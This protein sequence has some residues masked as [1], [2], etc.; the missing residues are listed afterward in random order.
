MWYTIR[1]TDM[2]S[3]NRLIAYFH[4]LFVSICYK[5]ITSDKQISKH[6][7]IDVILYTNCEAFKNSNLMFVHSGN[8][9][10]QIEYVD[11]VIHLNFLSR[12]D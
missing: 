12:Y 3:F 5:H 11:F 8:L 9:L 7:W 10:A 4:L 6:T 2:D 1:F